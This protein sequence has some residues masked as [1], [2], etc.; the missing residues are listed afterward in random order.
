MS[1]CS[2]HGIHFWDLEFR[3]PGNIIDHRSESDFGYDDEDKTEMDSVRYDLC[4]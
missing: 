3:E 1:S 4:F 2:R